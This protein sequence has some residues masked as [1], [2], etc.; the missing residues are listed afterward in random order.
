M[1]AAPLQT[2][3]VLVVGLVLAA[4]LAAFMFLRPGS[5]DSTSS[6][7]AVT[8]GK[9]SVV[10]PK[11]AT[12]PVAPKP[13]KP[14]IVLNPGLPSNVA[15]ALHRDRVVVVAVFAP[16]AGDTEAVAQARAG[17]KATGAGFV[18]LNVLEERKA[19]ALEKLVGPISDPSVL[20]IK[21]P[22]TI[23]F[24]ADGFADATT[25]AQAARIAGAR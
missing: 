15:R 5:D 25:V 21:R 19:R 4:A 23:S 6:T 11:P 20:V 7:P 10:T 12:H 22:G 1:N 14:V 18:A 8:P 2:R 24:R 16:K 13:V 9:S 3:L 17:A